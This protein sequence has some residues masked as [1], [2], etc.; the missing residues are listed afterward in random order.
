[1]P[2]FPCF[3]DS[4]KIDTI[5]VTWLS[6]E[7]HVMSKLI[8]LSVKTG[9]CWPSELREILHSI[10]CRKEKSLSLKGT[11]FPKPPH[12]NLLHT[13]PQKRTSL[14]IDWRRLDEKCHTQACIKH[15]YECSQAVRSKAPRGLESWI[16]SSG[17]Q[18]L[19]LGR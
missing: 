9:A 8:S 11:E 14:G 16:K 19:I 12:K 15:K 5:R 10:T 4:L 13:K 17:S 3:Q 18:E 1:M 2:V 6:G 7:C